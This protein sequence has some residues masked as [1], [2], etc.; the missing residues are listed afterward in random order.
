MEKN[1]IRQLLPQDKEAYE[2]Y[3]RDFL[4]NGCFDLYSR[5]LLAK[6][7]KYDGDFFSFLA[8]LDKNSRP[9]ADS[10]R[11]P[12]LEYCL[13]DK[14]GRIVG[15][16]RIRT[17]MTSELAVSTG[18]VGYDVRPAARRNGYG[19]TL[20]KFALDYFKEETNET[21]I[22]VSASQGNAA[23][24]RIIESCGGIFQYFWEEPGEEEPLKIY[25]FS[26]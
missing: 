10:G 25:R 18:N 14:A 11:V 19:L 23:S 3:R 8:L 22:I 7:E 17:G 20:L 9:A 6:F 15:S 4:E 12:Q 21:A 13:F 24:Q 2:E 1:I 26:L 16:V 5:E